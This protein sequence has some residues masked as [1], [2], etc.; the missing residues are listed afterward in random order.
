MCNPSRAN[1]NPATVPIKFE[2]VNRRA[3]RAV[4]KTLKIPKIAT[5]IRQPN[6]VAL[7][8]YCGTEAD[9]RADVSLP[10]VD[11]AQ[12][13]FLARYV[14][15]AVSA[16]AARAGLSLPAGQ[17][18]AAAE[19]ATDVAA[20]AHALQTR[21]PPPPPP[22]PPPPAP[23][24]AVEERRDKL[25]GAVAAYRDAVMGERICAV[26]VPKPGASVTLDTVCAHFEAFGL[27]RFKWP[28]RLR[29]IPQL[30]RN[31]VGKVL[32]GELSRLASTED[33]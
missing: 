30:P 11:S 19:V 24:S 4:I 2:F 25:E 28:E 8:R 10:R 13:R 12:R 32:R 22:P 16:A 26:V 15:S 29:V 20:I 7:R 17:A 9:P 1:N 18:A 33:G 6:G 5:A 31:S 27:A 3:I 21:A 23:A 14:E